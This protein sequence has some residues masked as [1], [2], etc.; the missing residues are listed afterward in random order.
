MEESR[1]GKNE[2]SGRRVKKWER[3][4]ISNV[5]EEPRG[6]L[7]RH[8]GGEQAMTGLLLVKVHCGNHHGDTCRTLL[9]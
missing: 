6:W 4:Q 2:E 3:V 1:C 5:E 8:D 7:M 9:R